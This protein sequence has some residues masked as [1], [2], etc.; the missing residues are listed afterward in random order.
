MAYQIAFQLLETENQ[1][2]VLKV[3]SHFEGMSNI[4]SAS[5]NSAVVTGRWIDVSFILYLFA[6]ISQLSVLKTTDL[7][8]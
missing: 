5:A 3:W 1:G 7:N 8:F 4:A 6:S 2:F